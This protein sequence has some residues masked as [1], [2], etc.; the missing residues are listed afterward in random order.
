M[1]GKLYVVRKEVEIQTV[2]SPE[3]QSSYFL[4]DIFSFSFSLLFLPTEYK[5]F[6]SN[7]VEFVQ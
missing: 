6:E 7:I 2:L 5:C 1:R 4:P 3:D